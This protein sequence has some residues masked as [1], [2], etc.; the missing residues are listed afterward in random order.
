MRSFSGKSVQGFWTYGLLRV[1]NSSG[2]KLVFRRQTPRL[3]NFSKF[4]NFIVFN[5]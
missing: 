2:L 4:D 5:L 3:S 1:L